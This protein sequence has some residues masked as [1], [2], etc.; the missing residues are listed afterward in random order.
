VASDLPKLGTV[1]EGPS[2]P[3]V[4]VGRFGYPRVSAGPLVPAD[5]KGGLD[6]SS[7]SGSDLSSHLFRRPAELAKMDVGEIV[8]LRSSMVRSG[9]KVEVADARNPGKLLEMAQEIA[10]S[11]TP[12]GTEVTFAK[13]PRG[14]LRFDGFMMPSGP[15]GSIEGM[16]ITSNPSIPRKVDAVVEDSDL[17]AAKA[18]GELYAS[19][20]EVD[21]ISRLL[22]LGLLGKKR[23]LVPTRW[24]I[25]AS[26]DIAGKHLASAIQDLSPVNEFLLFSGERLGNHFEVLLTPASFTYEL[27]EIWLPRSVWSGEEAWIGADREGPGPKKGYSDLAGGY[28]AARLALLERLA[29]MRRQASVLMVREISEK[30]WA[31]LGVWVVRE[32]AREA[33]RNPPR[34][35]ETLEEALAEMATRIRTPARDWRPHSE[36]ARG[37]GQTTLAKFF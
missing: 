25:T 5:E 16:E 11:S 26:D 22:S 27:V 12:V 9:S 33:L 3:E 19:G 4:F 8:A 34:K 24:S 13:P 18:V 2:P 14:R 37:V 15:S 36:L 6:L 35:F 32:A 10:M 30:Y 29:E 7:N 17:L 23:K 28:Y 1:V 20:V 31:P 21:G